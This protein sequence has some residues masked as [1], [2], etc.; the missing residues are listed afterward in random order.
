MPIKRKTAADKECGIFAKQINAFV[1]REY[2]F[3]YLTPEQHKGEWRSKIP[4]SQNVEHDIIKFAAEYIETG[5]SNQQL[6]K[7]QTFLNK[8]IPLMADYLAKYVA[9]SPNY[10]CREQAT[11]ALTEILKKKSTILTPRVRDAET[12]KKRDRINAAQAACKHRQIQDMFA[13][14]TRFT[15]NYS[16]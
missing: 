5:I 14:A 4:Y 7:L 8:L 10:K 3:Y 13:H 16:K 12:R 1:V 11:S 9:K 15:T 6:A 2:G